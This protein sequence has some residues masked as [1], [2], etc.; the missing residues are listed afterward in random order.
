MFNYLPFIASFD[1]DAT[2]SPFFV[3]SSLGLRKR[4]SQVWPHAE[5]A[6]AFVNTNSIL[7]EGG[8][9]VGLPGLQGHRALVSATRHAAL[10][11]LMDSIVMSARLLFVKGVN[12]GRYGTF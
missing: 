11:A 10:F 4:P 7:T 2:T 1:A 6:L 5:K 8:I 12:K 9:F 3:P